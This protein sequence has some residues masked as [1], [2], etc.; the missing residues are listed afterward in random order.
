M[1]A[2]YYGEVV[3]VGCYTKRRV[4]TSPMA[5]FGRA[6]RPAFNIWTNGRTRFR[7]TVQE[8]LPTRGLT[9]LSIS[10]R[11]SLRKGPDP[12]SGRALTRSWR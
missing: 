10:T 8:N 4:M 3:V 9:P 5:A 11:R 2:G 6:G 1:I 7:Q 12:V